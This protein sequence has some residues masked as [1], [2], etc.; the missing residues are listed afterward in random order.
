MQRSSFGEIVSR[1]ADRGTVDIEPRL[2][3]RLIADAHDDD[4]GMAIL[5]GASAAIK[6]ARTV[7]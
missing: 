7:S 6:I 4:G 1:P 2:T 5:S 3:E